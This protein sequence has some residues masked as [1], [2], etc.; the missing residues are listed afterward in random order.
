MPAEVHQYLRLL[1]NFV[2]CI[3]VLKKPSDENK[4]LTNCYLELRAI[5]DNA[6]AL[7]DNYNYKLVPNYRANTAV[8]LVSMLFESA[9]VAYQTNTLT[10]TSILQVGNTN[11]YLTLANI[12]KQI[13]I[14]TKKE[15]RNIQFIALA[16]TQNNEVWATTNYHTPV[17]YPVECL[18]D[19]NKYLQAERFRSRY[20]VAN[21]EAGA[22]ALIF[23]PTIHA[24]TMMAGLKDV[25]GISQIL[26]VDS[27]GK[28]VEN[29]PCCSH[30]LCIQG[31]S[32]QPH[33]EVVQNYET[34]TELQVQVVA[35]WVLAL[36]E[37]VG[38]SN[39]R[40]VSNSRVPQ[41]VA[42]EAITLGKQLLEQM[43]ML[44]PHDMIL[45]NTSALNQVFSVIKQ[46]YPLSLDEQKGLKDTY[47]VGRKLAHFE[48]T[49]LPRTIVRKECKTKAHGNLRLQFLNDQRLRVSDNKQQL[50]A[51]PD[52]PRSQALATRANTW[53]AHGKVV[54]IEHHKDNRDA[55]ITLTRK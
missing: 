49:E 35:N 32:S 2:K 50:I 55:P 34:P 51:E 43:F 31:F 29:C 54:T 6:R 26:I 27:T 3:D 38:T 30:Y 7:L 13:G 47:H 14:A 44:L 28:K 17:I 19:A 12:A 21:R 48:T 37:A 22:G 42:Q 25:L 40:F 46:Y 23:T 52:S 4:T 45:E 39:Y 41:T 53:L 15:P 20:K 33:M 8:L 5:R 36:R 9:K 1:N 11:Q 16:I 18:L 10:A 24:E